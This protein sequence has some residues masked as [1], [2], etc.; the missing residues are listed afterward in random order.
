MRT[1]Q[2]L[3]PPYEEY[4]T[5]VEDRRTAAQNPQVTVTARTDKV[6]YSPT[7]EILVRIEDR[8]IGFR[9]PRR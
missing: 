2:R 6:L 4:K 5:H 9:P 8:P 1:P 7:G 3:K